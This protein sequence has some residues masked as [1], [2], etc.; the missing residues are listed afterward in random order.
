MTK[1]VNK[2][3]GNISH[4]I[5][6]SSESIV[7]TLAKYGFVPRKCFDVEIIGKIQNNIHLWKTG[8]KYA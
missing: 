3:W 7:N 6:F 8:R 2:K 5:S 4:S 1:L